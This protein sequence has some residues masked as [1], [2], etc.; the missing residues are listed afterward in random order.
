M[1]KRS[2]VLQQD[3]CIATRKTS[4]VDTVCHGSIP[5]KI[6]RHVA[7][8][9]FETPRL[10]L[11]TIVI[12]SLHLSNAHAKKPVAGPHT[13]QQAVDAALTACR[14]AGRPDMDIVCGDANMAR[15]PLSSHDYFC[16]S[17]G[18]LKLWR[19]AV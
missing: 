13:L 2:W 17:S 3:Q 12:M 19:S 9:T 11:N 7:E 10:G 15:P 6:F 18:S 4:R 16:R 14:D 5:G 1:G 8:V